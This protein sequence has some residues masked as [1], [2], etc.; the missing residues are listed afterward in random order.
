MAGSVCT[1]VRG[2]DDARGWKHNTVMPLCSRLFANAS[3]QTSL[4]LFKFPLLLSFVRA[5]PNRL[6]THLSKWQPMATCHHTVIS[7]ATYRRQVLVSPRISEHSPLHFKLIFLRRVDA[8][9]FNPQYRPLPSVHTSDLAPMPT[10]WIAV[11]G[12]ITNIATALDLGYRYTPHEK[13]V[14]KNTGDILKEVDNILHSTSVVLENHK[15]LLPPKEYN[16]L[17]GMYRR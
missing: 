10:D 14:G 12:V 4:T 1:K 13:I 6:C 3:S 15:D 11:S 17:K 7:F 5:R 2:D 9:V 16:E 8:P